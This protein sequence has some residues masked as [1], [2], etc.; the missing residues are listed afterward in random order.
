MA[1]G[2]RWARRLSRSL[3]VGLPAAAFALASLVHAVGNLQAASPLP[4][5]K[6]VDLV[7]GR[8]IIC[9][10]LALVSQQ[11]QDRQGWTEIVDRMITWGAPI[12]P[13]ERRVIIEYLLRHLGRSQTP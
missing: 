10:D 9:H 7:I 11:R 2:L 12:T 6:D 13:D 3:L 4:P 1:S 8:C 5:G